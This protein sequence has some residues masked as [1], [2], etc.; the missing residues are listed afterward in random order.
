M[1]IEKYKDTNKYIIY[2]KEPAKEI[3]KIVLPEDNP[4]L[5]PQAPRYTKQER[6]FESNTL[7]ELFRKKG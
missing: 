1:K 7:E 2:F 4:S 3:D 5:A 6:L